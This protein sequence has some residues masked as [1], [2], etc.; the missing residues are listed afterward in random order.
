MSLFEAWPCKALR[1]S[2]TLKSEVGSAISQSASSV[3]MD[4]RMADSQCWWMRQENGG[5]LMQSNEIKFGY[6]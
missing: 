3:S 2:R 4:E 5:G 6:H 1:L